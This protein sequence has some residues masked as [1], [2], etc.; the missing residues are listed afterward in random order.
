[1]EV[2]VLLATC[3]RDG[4]LRSCLESLLRVEGS[5]FKW[6][7]LVV[8]NAGQ[9]ST[10]EL[11]ES[12]RG[13]LNVRYLL[14]ATP[15]K[16]NALNRA[17]EEAR[18]ELLVFTDDDIVA[19]PRWLHEMWRGA[20]RWP[21]HA[22]FAGR[23]LPKW[24]GAMGPP[25]GIN[26]PHIRAAFCIADWDLEEGPI[27]SAR[28]WGPNMAVRAG[29]FRSGIRFNAAVGPRGSN[30]V[31]G[32]ET[33]LT[34]RLESQGMGAIYLPRSVVWHQI[35]SEQLTIK[36]LHGRAYRAGRGEAFSERGVSSVPQVLGVPRFLLRQLAEVGIAR[37]LAR[38]RSDREE[39]LK[40]GMTYWRLRG[41]LY[42]RI[43][44]RRNSAARRAQLP[45]G[46][47]T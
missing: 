14:E 15:G 9:Q 42:Q 17:L 18:G 32:S 21:E 31:M 47:L 30:Y 6:E 3:R 20:A 22:V 26:D 5:G 19:D 12:Y 35:R 41:I 36:W 7:A 27:A 44:E 23:I 13:Q 1:M 38:F 33:E 4:T 43:Q 11:V 46:P 39:M 25:F 24:P 40:L 34:C 28:V 45:K 8:D 16:N 2:A 29:V 10:R 37:I